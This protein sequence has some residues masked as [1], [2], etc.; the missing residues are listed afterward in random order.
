MRTRSISPFILCGLLAWSD[1]IAAAAA[2]ESNDPQRVK[3]VPAEARGNGTDLNKTTKPTGLSA[4]LDDIVKLVGA[5]IE[6]PVI[7]AFIQNSPVA[8]RPSAQEIIK[9]RELGVSGSIISA[10]LRRGD[11]VRQR[12]AERQK[13]TRPAAPAPAT[14]DQH[15][16]AP[17]TASVPQSTSVYHV[18]STYPVVYPRVVYT[19]GYPTYAYPNY[20]HG[21][22][23]YPRYYSSCYPRVS[24]YGG[25]YPRLSFG[26]HFG[27]GHFGYH[28]G[29]RYCR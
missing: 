5:G 29:F 8:Y 15:Q 7:L 17:P 4:G 6:E 21:G 26:L 2:P 24:Y 28:G 10:L 9:L 23:Y 18:P 22:C 1:H 19:T 16:P 12:A 11:E 13:E 20:G 27:G 14:N 25:F 3:S